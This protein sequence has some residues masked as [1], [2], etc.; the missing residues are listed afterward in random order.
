MWYI[1]LT[2]DQYF[3]VVFTKSKIHKKKEI[4]LSNLQKVLVVIDSYTSTN[5]VP[6]MDTPLLHG[7]DSNT[8]T[9][10]K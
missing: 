4:K 8:L 7:I 1:G 2:P 5:S 3:E 9:S 10:L 6:M